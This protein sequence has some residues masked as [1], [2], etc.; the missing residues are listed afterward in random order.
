MCV[1][2][3]NSRRS[4]ILT[5]EIDGMIPL[6]RKTFG[7]GMFRF[8]KS[9]VLESSD[10]RG[11]GVPVF[12]IATCAASVSRMWHR[13]DLSGLFAQDGRDPENREPA[14]GNPRI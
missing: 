8:D 1:A 9:I 10:T 6:P 2:L 12:A 3:G 14:G 11:G 13:C 5:W 7:S 4:P